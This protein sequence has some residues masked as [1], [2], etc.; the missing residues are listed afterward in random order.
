MKKIYGYFIAALFSSC[1]SLSNAA[2]TTPE[3]QHFENQWKTAFD[4]HNA[5]TL[6]HFYAKDAVFM[7]AFQ[8]EPL[9][10]QE[11]R[12]QYFESLFNKAKKN[13]Q[14]LTVQFD[15]NNHYIHFVNGGA[16][17]S[18]VYFLEEQK[19]GKVTRIPIRF[20]MV[21]RDSPHNCKLIVHQASI[22]PKGTLSQ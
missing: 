15:N 4:S 13:N 1:C 8:H 16:V 11:A 6:T 19:G 3:L 5:Q 10:T 9:L 12:I 2:C 14:T 7:G 21:Y 20:T 22:V 17:C 18:G